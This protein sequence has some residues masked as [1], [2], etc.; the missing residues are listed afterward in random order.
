VNDHQ[1][2]GQFRSFKSEIQ[3]EA[4]GFLVFRRKNG[5]QPDVHNAV[6]LALVSPLATGNCTQ[7]RLPMPASDSTPTCP[8]IRSTTF[9]TMARPMPVPC[10]FASS[11]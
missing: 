8:P 6:E 11:F 1:G 3:D 7:K 2:V 5:P 9:R 10:Y 4:V